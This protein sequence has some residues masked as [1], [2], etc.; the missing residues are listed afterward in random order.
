MR[1]LPRWSALIAGLLIGLASWLLFI[2]EG[3]VDPNRVASSA[4]NIGSE[5]FNL[6]PAVDGRLV[7]ATGSLSSPYA[8]GD[9]LF[10]RPG[11]Y[12]AIIRKVEMFSWGSREAKTVKLWQEYPPSTVDRFVN[13]RKKLSSGF[14]KVK[15]L[16]VGVYDVDATML[17]FPA[18]FP[19]LQLNAAKVKELGSFRQVSAR[20]LFTG[21]GTINKPQIGD[22]RVS[23][24]ALPMGTTV[25]VFGKLSNKMIA[26][27]LDQNN[28]RL[29]RLFLGDRHDGLRQLRGEFRLSVWVVRL[30]AWLLVC[31]GLVVVLELMAGNIKFPALYRQILLAG[32]GLTVLLVWLTNWIRNFWLLLIVLCLLAGG[33]VYYLRRRR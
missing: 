14:Y 32:F 1:S 30:V 24:F 17:G 15:E 33:T 20:Y 18:K 7:S 13:P 12:I 31:L 16:K 26:P 28:Y 21:Q 9:S 4:V 29:Y 27:Y 25:T 10:I 8:L 23:Y 19:S 11:N 6:D 22:L 5:R 2:N 3:R